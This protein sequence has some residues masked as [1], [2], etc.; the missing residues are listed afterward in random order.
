[1][2]LIRA[3]ELAGMIDVAEAI[4]AGALAE[5]ESR[6]SHARRDYPSATTKAS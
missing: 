2:E 5:K 4:A 3:Y 6:G 1:M